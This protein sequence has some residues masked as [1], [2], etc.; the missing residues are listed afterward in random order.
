MRLQ[1]VAGGLGH[2]TRAA[3]VNNLSAFGFSVMIT[4]SF[5]AL[6]AKLGSPGTAEV[7]L[8][9][10]GAVGGV[11]VI[12]GI[13]SKGFRRQ[14]RGERSDVV[15]LGTGVGFVSVGL[16]IGSATLLAEIVDG[17]SAWP[18][19]SFLAS[20]LYVLLSGAEMAL[21]KVLQEDREADTEREE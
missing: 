12:D 17:G 14:L 5:G 6:A 20:S 18:L 4:A 2:G 11:T 8:F 10:A 1:K 21:A 7:F 19:G 15:A 3:L 13:S 9:A 16:A